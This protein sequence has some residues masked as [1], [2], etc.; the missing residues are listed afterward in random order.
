MQDSGRGP[1]GA[2]G[3]FAAGA[4]IGLREHLRDILHALQEFFLERFWNKYGRFGH[5][6][7]DRFA[8]LGVHGFQQGLVFF[9]GKGGVETLAL[10]WMHAVLSV[11][12]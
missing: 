10:K 8:E 9:R 1:L 12:F 2:R 4:K 5:A 11:E 7:R 3:G 6:E